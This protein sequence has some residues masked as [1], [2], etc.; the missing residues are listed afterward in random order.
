[1]VRVM[2]K[3]EDLLHIPVSR[4]KAKWRVK[5]WL[6]QVIGL[7]LKNEKVELAR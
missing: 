3:K 2:D 6:S 1:M 4:P 5:I 7:A